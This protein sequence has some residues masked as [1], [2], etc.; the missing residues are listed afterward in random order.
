MSELEAAPRERGW[1]RLLPAVAI[2]LLVPAVPQLRAA[3]PIEQTLLLLLPALAVC[4][5]LGW[6]LGGRISLAL[7]WTALAVWVLMRPMAAGDEYAAFARAWALLLAAG[8]GAIGLVAGARPFIA[9]ALGTV[10]FSLVASLMLLG[11]AGAGPLRL[12]RAMAAELSDRVESSVASLRARTQT[13]DWAKLEQDNPDG[14]RAISQMMDGIENQLRQIAPFGENF[15]LA[16]LAFESLVAL[17]LAWSLYHRLARTRIGPPLSKLREFR[18]DDQLIWGVVAALVMVLLPRLISLKWLGQNAL[19][20]F[21]VLYGLRGLG[22]MIWFLVAPGRWLGIVF[23]TL[24]A[25]FYPLWAIPLGVG[26]GD[27]W[28]DLRRRLRPTNQGSAQ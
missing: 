24:V 21:G 17:G 27:T 28:W 13:A 18:F 8:F 15:F 3:L 7:A 10:A 16:L 11:M 19:A 6:R 25:L 9:R 4:S 12:T 26:L 23:V 14:A 20:F 1:R 5:W 2:F 22:V